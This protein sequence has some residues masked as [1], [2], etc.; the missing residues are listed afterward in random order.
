MPQEDAFPRSER[1]VPPRSRPVAPAPLDEQV[2]VV[3][4]CGVVMTLAWRTAE[5][6]RCFGCGRVFEAPPTATATPLRWR[7][8]LATR[9]ESPVLPVVKIVAIVAILAALLAAAV[10]LLL[11]R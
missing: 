1:K 10:T 8:D 4:R 7:P 11:R 5:P 2:T 3:C 9:P 6:V